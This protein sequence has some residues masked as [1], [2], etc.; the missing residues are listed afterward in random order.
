MGVLVRVLGAAVG[1]AVSLLVGIVGVVVLGNSPTVPAP[2][3]PAPSAGPVTVTVTAAAPTATPTATPSL[4]FGP[5][6]S[7]STATDMTTPDA[8]QGGHAPV[9]SKEAGQAT[10]TNTHGG[11]PA[12]PGA[13]Q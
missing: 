4:F 6:R 5:F 11:E 12:A 9:P 10:V 8:E 3:K 7:T 1:A 2:R 13:P